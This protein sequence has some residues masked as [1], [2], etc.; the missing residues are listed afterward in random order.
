MSAATLIGA[1][2]VVTVLSLAGLGLVLDR[3]DDREQALLAAMEKVKHAEW[4][5]SRRVALAARS[6]TRV[7]RG[8]D[9]VSLTPDE[10]WVFTQIAD[11]LEHECRVST[12]TC[13]CGHSGAVH[14]HYRTRS[15]CSRCE[16]GRYR[17]RIVKPE[18]ERS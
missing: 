6:E 4:E 16:C 7:T 11:R 9:H 14:E 5:Q 1:G 8:H 17:R 2:M 12:G 3:R 10:E 13:V 15:D 18:R